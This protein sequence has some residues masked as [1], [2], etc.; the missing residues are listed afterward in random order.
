MLG[1]APYAGHGLPGNTVFTQKLFFTFSQAKLHESDWSSQFLRQLSLC[2][3]ELPRLLV[4]T[5][6][7]IGQR[8]I[9]QICWAPYS[10]SSYLLVISGRAKVFVKTNPE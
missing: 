3:Q 4:Q 9:N 6:A 5:L 8:P 1:G 7:V 2:C 10:S